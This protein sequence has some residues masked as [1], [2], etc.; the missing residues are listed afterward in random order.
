MHHQIIALNFFPPDQ[1]GHAALVQSFAV[2][3]VAFLARPFGGALIG[4]LGDRFGRKLALETSL[5]AMAVPTFA[6]GCLP[7]YSM[8]SWGATVLLVTCRMFQGLSVGG[9]VMTSVVFTLERKERSHWGVWGGAVAAAQT[10]GVTLGSLFSYVLREALTVEQVS[11]ARARPYFR[12]L[13]IFYPMCCAV[14][15]MR[16]LKLKL[17]TWGWR[18]PFFFG[19]LGALPGLYL[20]KYGTEHP[21]PQIEGGTVA[22]N[23]EGQPP[24]IRESAFSA[25]FNK[26]N[27]RAL[28][29]TT[30]VV[31][32]PAAG[33]YVI[34]IWLAIFMESIVDPPVPHAFAI[35]TIVGVLAVL[36]TVLGGWIADRVGRYVCLMVASGLVLAAT[37]P[38]VLALIGEGDPVVAFLCQAA[39]GALFVVW[40]GAMTPWI[41]ASFPPALRLTSVNI[42]YNTA[43]CVFGG[44]APGVATLLV[45]AFGV[46]APG[47]YLTSIAGLSL[48]GLAIA[49]KVSEASRACQGNDDV[50]AEAEVANEAPA[51]SGVIT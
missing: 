14:A 23:G 19:I 36:G 50:Y 48:L 45:D 3:G 43:V 33:Y 51:N 7:T 41:V 22:L 30:L 20:K 31:A 16:T 9:Q 10:A 5:L 26:S 44:S 38:F 13:F 42:G 47:F 32:L 34:F 27:M 6:M 40:N 28:L 39:L 1:A 2:F 17:N 4:Q 35:N 29:S 8:I 15:L 37:S 46:Y 18:I 12:A 11:N 24:Q 49:P 25:S 21:V